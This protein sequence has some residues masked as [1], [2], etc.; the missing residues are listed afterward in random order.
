MKFVLKNIPEDGGCKIT[1]EVPE[2]EDEEFAE[3]DRTG[4]V[5][6][7]VN[8]YEANERVRWRDVV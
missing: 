7:L 3:E 8:F 2:E 4:I 5:D 6:Y 1:A